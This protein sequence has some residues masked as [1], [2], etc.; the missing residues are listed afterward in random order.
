MNSKVSIVLPIYNVEKYIERSI[1]SLLTQTYSNIEIIMV[2]DGSTD[3]SLKVMKKL[4]KT[5]N[6]IKIFAQKNLG[7]GLARQKGV[8]NSTGEYIVFV[9]PDDYLEKDSIKNNINIMKNIR[10]DVI[11][12]GYTT[13]FLNRLGKISTIETKP[14][15]LGLYNRNQFIENFIMFSEINIRPLWNKMYKKDFLI[16]NNITFG[17]QPVGQDAI[18]NF[19]V[20]KHVES[21]YLDDSV[22]YFYDNT[23]VN[24]AVKKYNS[25]RFIY[26]KNIANKLKE[27]FRYWNKLHEYKYRQLLLHQYWVAI[28]QE[29]LNISHNDS[30]LGFEQKIDL[31]SKRCQDQ[32]IIKVL[33]RYNIHDTG[34][35]LSK[36][37]FKLLKNRQ[38][39]TVLILV[40][41]YN[42]LK[43]I[44]WKK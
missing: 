7:S 15:L 30:N 16:K 4:R 36:I 19:E 44:T 37:I 39:R 21:I 3:D 20:Y 25:D 34:S 13:Q 31:L 14:T 12:N 18:F 24:S 11:V 40:K 28:F 5:D 33:Q 43:H 35:R 17:N 6:R 38:Y 27:L 29:I 9:D 26:D 2:D 32:D 42:K 22:Y 10:P 41:F 8:D 23:R 1:H